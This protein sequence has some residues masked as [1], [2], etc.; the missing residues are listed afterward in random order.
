MLFEL[1]RPGLEPDHLLLESVFVKI[2]FFF[3]S[4]ASGSWYYRSVISKASICNVDA[5]SKA[6]VIHVWYRTIYS[7]TDMLT[8]FIFAQLMTLEI[9]LTHILLFTKIPFN[10]IVGKDW[11]RST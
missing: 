5:F 8:G 9:I 2:S 10:F 7:L 3:F 1:A 4:F 11:L 6:E